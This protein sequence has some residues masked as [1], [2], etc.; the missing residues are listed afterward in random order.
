MPWRGEVVLR[1][2]VLKGLMPGKVE[3]SALL[4]RHERGNLLVAFGGESIDTRW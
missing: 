4:G 2:V 1:T 3:R